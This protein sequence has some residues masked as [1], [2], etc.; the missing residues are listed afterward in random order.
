MLRVYANH[1]G[2][3][4]EANE[5]KPLCS[6][7]HLS[8]N[9]YLQCDSRSCPTINQRL[10]AS[11]LCHFSTTRTFTVDAPKGMPVTFGPLLLSIACSLFH[12]RISK[13]SAMLV[14]FTNMVAHFLSIHLCLTPEGRGGSAV[15]KR[16]F[17]RT[18]ERWLQANLFSHHN[19]SLKI[20][21]G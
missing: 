7:H 4:P 14:Q 11:A 5:H 15:I 3:I 6:L 9:Q 18:K 12:S 10:R 1:E 2:S 21:P 13:F 16:G 19:I 8:P 20:D 17:R